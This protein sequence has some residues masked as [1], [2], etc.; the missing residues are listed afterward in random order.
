MTCPKC[1]HRMIY[2]P[3]QHRLWYCPDCGYTIKE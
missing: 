2:V 3:A 1:G